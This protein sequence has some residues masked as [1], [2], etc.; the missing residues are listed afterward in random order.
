VL[1]RI[2]GWDK[3][4]GFE[5]MEYIHLNFGKGQTGMTRKECVKDLVPKVQ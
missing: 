3:N 2:N 1:A 4:G 5:Y